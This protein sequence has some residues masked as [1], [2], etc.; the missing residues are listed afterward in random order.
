MKM[1]RWGEAVVDL[2]RVLPHR[3]GEARKVAHERLAAVCKA[4]GQDRLAAV[5]EEEASNQ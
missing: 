1:E 4:L 3:T 5:H 2:E